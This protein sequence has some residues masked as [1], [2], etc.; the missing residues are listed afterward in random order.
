M[1]TN[2]HSVPELTYDTKPYAAFL[3]PRSIFKLRMELKEAT[4]AQSYK[5]LNVWKKSIDLV[6]DFY[7]ATDL[8]PRHELFGIVSQARC[9]FYSK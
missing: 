9:C 8:F 7:T 5:Q 3:A 6:D 4:M 1:R 2:G